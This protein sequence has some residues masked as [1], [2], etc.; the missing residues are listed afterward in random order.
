MA[1][2][3]ILKAVPVED[4]AQK[5]GVSPAVAQQAIEQAGGALLSGLAKNAESPDGSA[6]IEKALS[7]HEG[8]TGASSVDEIDT[9]DGRKILQ[10]VFGDKEKDVAATLNSSDKTAGGIDFGALLPILAP[11]VMGLIANNAK[12]SAPAEQAS[13]GGIGDL[14]GGLLGGGGNSGGGIDLGGVIG[15]LLGGGNSGGSGGGLD[16]GGLIGGLL[17]GGKK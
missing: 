4:I 10:H 14:V 11:I 15:G 6:A 8:F 16:L 17:G 2:E 9:A 1:I 7:K 3:D 12:P 13:G 5:L